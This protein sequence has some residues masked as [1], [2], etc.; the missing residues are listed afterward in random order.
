MGSGFTGVAR[1]VQHFLELLFFA[2]GLDG[3]FGQAHLQLG[4]FCPGQ[5]F[6]AGTP[7]HAPMAAE[8]A[9]IE[10]GARALRAD[11]VYPLPAS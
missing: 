5:F 4:G 7:C 10:F 3:L 6:P 1:F 11:I 2:L 8:I 9:A